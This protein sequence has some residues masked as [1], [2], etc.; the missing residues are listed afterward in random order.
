M[1]Q[2]Y[3]FAVSTA[4]DATMTAPILFVGS[5]ADNIKKASK[6]GYDAVEI[7]LRENSEIDYDNIL[8]LCEE[9][10]V[11]IAT[12]VTGRLATQENIT[13][14]DN[15]PENTDRVLKGLKQYIEIAEKFEADI[16]IGWIRGN[17]L[18][19]QSKEDYEKILAG[20]LKIV[21]E[22]AEQRNVKVHIEAINRYE[23]NSLNNAAE[24]LE[25]INN[26]SIQN[27]YVHLD[28]FHMNIEEADMAEAIKLCGDKLG[29]VHFA[30]SNRNYPGKGHID[31][32]K[33]FVAL[34]EIDYKGILSVECLPVPTHGE[35]AK[36][37]RENLLKIIN[38]LY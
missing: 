13:L 16:I 3:K 35:A 15:S 23:I 17:I 26:Y 29:Y 14:T 32:K 18:E 30:D 5:I 22:Y 12:I 4:G 7:H 24:I 9:Y 37:A 25:I 20:N 31:F 38:N 6:F 33:I 1:E 11:K 36:A 19:N 10:N 28:T 8:K 2:K 21:S 34:K 27:V